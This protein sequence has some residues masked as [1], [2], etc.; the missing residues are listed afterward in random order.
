MVLVA[1]GE[2]PRYGAVAALGRVADLVD[3]TV[4]SEAKGADLGFPNT[5][6]RFVGRLGSSPWALDSADVVVLAGVEL[7]EATLPLPDFGD[8]VVVQVS[9][10]A[11][12]LRRQ[13]PGRVGIL[14]D[15]RRLFEGVA[16]RLEAQGGASRAPGVWVREMRARFGTTREALRTRLIDGAGGRVSTAGPA[17]PRRPARRRLA[18]RR[19]GRGE[20]AHPARGHTPDAT[21]A[22][23]THREQRGPAVATGPDTRVH[24]DD[25]PRSACRWASNGGLV[26]RSL[27]SVRISSLRRVSSRVLILQESWWRR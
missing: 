27:G 14:G 4:M 12:A 6:P 1:G 18:R 16:S 9:T 2:V 26:V 24:T 13:H 11:L 21:V 17:D 20:G 5:H 23:P 10:D 19:R 8:A 7:T 25:G 15:P 22:T 3:A